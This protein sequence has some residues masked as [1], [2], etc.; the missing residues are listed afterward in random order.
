MQREWHKE[1]T[2][3]NSTIFTGVCNDKFRHCANAYCDS[4]WISSRGHSDDTVSKAPPGVTNEY[5]ESHRSEV[6]PDDGTTV[7][8]PPD[9]TPACDLCT[10]GCSACPSP[11]LSPANGSSSSSPG[12][13]H[14]ANL[15]TDGPYS[16][17]YWYVKAP[18]ETTALGTN[19]EI[20]SGDGTTIK[21]SLNYTFPSGAMH[22]GVFK[23]TAY[24]YPS[25]GSVYEYSYIVNVSLD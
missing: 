20:D 25:T 19:V 24:I 13:T 8:T 9:N 6:P 16:Q 15:I 1:R 12:G 11:G 3:N 5:P 4:R 23:I 21:A 17:V 2:C 14:T 7:I 22:T 10:N 18:W